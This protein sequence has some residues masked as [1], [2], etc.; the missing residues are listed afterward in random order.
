MKKTT[1]YY[2][3]RIQDDAVYYKGKKL[4]EL[5]REQ[6][7]HL[8]KRE[9]ERIEIIYSGG[10]SKL[11]DEEELDKHNEGT[12]GIYNISLIPYYLACI[13]NGTIVTE[14]ATGEILTSEYPEALGIRKVSKE[15]F[16]KFIHQGNYSLKAKNYFKE[17]TKEKEP[18]KVI[19]GT[20]DVYNGTAYLSGKLNGELYEGTFT[21]SLR[22]KR[23]DKV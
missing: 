12:K 22:L 11:F 9:L 14:L 17:I 8:Y 18:E 15:E 6:L 3:V 10:M 1:N 21:G 7:P 5:L 13:G 4:I 20:E 16:I 2:L 19:E 23:K